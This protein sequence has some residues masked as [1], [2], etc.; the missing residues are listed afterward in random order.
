MRIKPITPI[1]ML[2][3]AYDEAANAIEFCNWYTMNRPQLELHEQQLIDIAYQDGV[4]D[5][6]QD[7]DHISKPGEYYTDNYDRNNEQQ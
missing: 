6:I 1:Q 2:K 3:I 4:N 7:P 5:A